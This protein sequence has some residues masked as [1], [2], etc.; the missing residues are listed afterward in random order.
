MFIF[1]L[2]RITFL[3]I[4][5]IETIC[6][7]LTPMRRCP[8]SIYVAYLLFLCLVPSDDLSINAFCVFLKV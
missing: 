1:T 5:H 8:S 3:L 4:I 2:H 7:L 6:T